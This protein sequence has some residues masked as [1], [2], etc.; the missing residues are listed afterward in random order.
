[1]TRLRRIGAGGALLALAFAWALARPVP[2]AAHALLVSSDPARNASVP[3]APAVITLD[4]TEAPDPKLSSVQVL[5]SAGHSHG[6]AAASVAGQPDELQVVP[7]PLPD[8]IYTVAWRTVSSVD[9]HL[10]AGSFAFSIG[11]PAP[12][13]GAAGTV[14]A[15]VASQ[16]LSETFG[17]WLLFV[18]LIAMV[19]GAFVGGVLAGA[20]AP[21]VMRFVG[22]AWLVAVAGTV[23]LVLSQA[24]GLGVPFSALLSSS[25]GRAFAARAAPL[26][27][28]G[29]VALA[30]RRRGAHPRHLLL[31]AGFGAALAML[32][33]AAYSHA[34]AGTAPL[35]NVAL[36][37]L[38]IAAVGVWIGGVAGLLLQVRGGPSDEKARTARRFAIAAAV[39]LA[40]VGL[41][42]LIRAAVELGTP[43]Q[44]LSSDFGH[45]VLVKS[46]LLGLLVV[47]GALNHFRNVP[48]APRSL[49][50]L[51]LTG[52]T[53]LIVA[54][55]VLLAAAE[56]VNVPP[57]TEV[58]ASS[59]A[60][61]SPP[62]LVVSG[63]DYG[64]SVRLRL[65][66]SPGTV[67]PNRFAATVSDYDTGAAVAATDVQLHFALLDR[68][69]IGPSDL[70]LP[71]VGSGSFAASGSNLSIEGTWAVTALVDDGLASVEVPLQI[72]ARTAPQVVDV[73]R[74]PGNPTLYTIHL[75]AGRTVQVYLD[76]DKPATSNDFH[77]TYFDAGGNELPVSSIAISAGPSSGPTRA[78]TVRTL[79]PGHVVATLEV[80][81]GPET[82]VIVG[83][84]PGGA[85]L[86]AQLTIIPGT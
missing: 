71:R 77:V 63:H 74:A 16:P 57:P 13:G 70:T 84:A 22:G 28:I 83:T 2:T 41:T 20:P 38:H 11:I 32:V 18:G 56:L 31:L 75:G 58:L 4:F 29:L 36:Q 73:V 82:F 62:A 60:S 49:R 35:P 7:G 85:T 50:G 54:T 9:G 23:A 34:A 65:T 39:A 40:V 3:V 21:A 80:G 17:H 48:T 1:M 52:T 79:E 68:P 6:A 10:A 59:Q 30:A 37:W 43:G 25:L 72:V 47:L 8:G 51:R 69:D 66:V 61:S 15:G 27:F 5:D 14:P 24:S 67:G 76:P 53:E 86:R 55:I 26:V 78:L 45:L 81:T 64:T 19:G 33:D 46:A 12:T 44:L 42:G